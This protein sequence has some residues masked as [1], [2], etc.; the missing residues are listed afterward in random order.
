MTGLACA[1]PKVVT[2]AGC[3]GKPCNRIGTAFGQ[4]RGWRR[5]ARR[6]TGRAERNAVDPRG[7]FS[8]ARPSIPDRE[9]TQAEDPPR[10]VQSGCRSARTVAQPSPAAKSGNRGP[11]LGC[12]DPAWERACGGRAEIGGQARRDQGF[13]RRRRERAGPLE[14]S[15]SRSDHSVT[16]SRLPNGHTAVK[17][18]A[19]DCNCSA[20]SIQL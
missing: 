1:Q 4:V 9:T 19:F 11:F 14:R 3:R 15:G 5:V 13:L 6:P 2:D 18:K 16:N 10:T 7:R 20:F 17:L 8:A 12:R